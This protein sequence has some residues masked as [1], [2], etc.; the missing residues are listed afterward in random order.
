M[1]L[2][3]SLTN[4]GPDM[5][6]LAAELFPIHR[7]LVNSGYD[8][9][10]DIIGREIP[11]QIEAYPS[12]AKAWDWTIPM[13]WDVR[14]AWV[15]DMDGRRL[16]DFA[17]S[18]LHLAAYSEPFSGEVTREELFTHLSFLEN[19]PSAIPFRYRYYTGGWEFCVRHDDLERFASDR[20]RV[21]VDV[22]V[23][24]GE[25][26]AASCVIPGR[27]NHEILFTTYLCHPSLAN[28][29]LSGVVA[30]VNLF[31]HLLGGEYHH[32]LRLLIVPETVGAIAWMAHNEDKLRDIAGG[33]VVYD[34]GDRANVSYK[35]SYF[36]DSRVDRAALHAMSRRESP[37]A[38][39]EWSP[40]GSDERQFNAPGVRLPFGCVMRSGA[41]S[42]PQYHTS[43]DTLDIL[44]AD[45]LADTVAFLAEA[46]FILDNDLLYENTYRAE[47]FISAHDIVYPEYTFGKAQGKVD[48]VKAMIHELDGTNTLLDIAEKWGFR[49][50]DVHEIAQAF[51]TAGLVRQASPGA[52]PR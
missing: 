34:C 15:E 30:G 24:P 4:A 11:L 16:V 48:I 38:V 41:S 49:F 45:S 19:Q 9:S 42:Y 46:L 33:Y 27:T 18:N 36:G 1:T 8:R 50:E 21:M 26:K 10:L 43:L 40:H 47:P 52:G 12:G 3:P 20:Y 51:K 39:F 6:R 5:M 13:A 28:D 25:L 44:S 14:E 31:K 37:G 29:N 23:R 17:D 22:N 32:T 7:T 2:K 35:K